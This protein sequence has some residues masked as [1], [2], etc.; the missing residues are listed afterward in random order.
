VGSVCPVCGQC[1]CY[2]PITPY[3]RYAI[4]IFPV[5]WKERVPVARFLCRGLNVT[6]SLLPDLLIPYMLYTASSVVGTLL[7]GLSHWQAGM[8]GFFG[9]TQNVDPDSRITP[10]LVTCWLQ[11]VMSGFRRSHRILIRWFDLGTVSDP[12][13][14]GW[15]GIATYFHVLEWRGAPPVGKKLR[16]LL[17][18][19]I[20]AVRKFLFGIPYQERRRG[21][22]I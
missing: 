22:D 7:V 10:W 16:N 4:D 5:F 13:T 3:E 20:R 15:Q 19:Y 9:A 2:R 18:Q 14:S 6:F 12:G 1:D 17:H 8:K 21:S 11:I